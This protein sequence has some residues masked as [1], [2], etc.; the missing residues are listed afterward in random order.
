MPRSIWAV[1]EDLTR[2]AFLGGRL[3]VWQPR[4]GYRAGVDAVLLAAAVPAQA[5]DSVLELGCGVGTAALCLA[6]RVR[7]LTLTGVELQQS[8][9]DL[10]RRNAMENT[11]DIAVLT[12]DIAA[13]PDDLR[14]RQFSHVIMNPPYFDRSAG[15]AAADAGRDK[16]LG[17][18][19]P[20]AVWL[21]VGIR[22]IAAKGDLVVIQRMERLPD[23]LG[24][25]GGRLGT[26]VVCP[27][28]GRA[29]HAPELFLLRA[30]QGGRAPF[31][32]TP[33]LVLHDG[34]VHTRDAESYTPMIRDVLR[35]G[36]ALP[37]WD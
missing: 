9:A 31:R 23:V 7:G 2:D 19:T 8:Y 33:P 16:A 37:V 28:T 10:A 36:A 35:N 3:H 21:D 18:D 5:G 27:I 30:K 1:T 12:A 13:L 29:G 25:I 14:Q 34:A 32:M 15:T 20:L 6:A 4:K 22:R 26:I 11:M 17:G 24:V